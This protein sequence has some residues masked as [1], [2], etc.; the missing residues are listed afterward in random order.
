[1]NKNY[2]NVLSTILDDLNKYKELYDREY[3]IE[4]QDKK[5]EIEDNIN[6]ILEEGRNLK[7]G[8]VGAVKAGKSS[9][10]NALIFNGEDVL[11]KAST[12][13]TAAL[14]KINYSSEAKFKVNF[15]ESKEWEVIKER[16][17]EYDKKFEEYCKQFN[18]LQ[19]KKDLEKSFIHY[20]KLEGQISILSCKELT[21]MASKSKLDLND[22]LGKSDIV[23]NKKDLENYI[24]ANGKYTAIVK[25]V[26]LYIDNS[27]LKGIEIIDTPGLNDPILSRA[28][29][30]KK[31]LGQCDVV[32]VL[33]YA[34]QFFDKEDRKL[35]VD[36]LPDKGVKEIIIV[37]SKF[38]SGV[39]DDNVSE[40]YK[41]ASKLLEKQF[42]IRASEM[43]DEI[44]D[45]SIVSEL[46]KSLPPVC[47]SSMLFTCAKKKECGNR[48]SDEELK[49]INNLKER[50]VD[51]SDD[52]KDL[53][54]FSGIHKI[55]KKLNEIMDESDKIIEEKNKNYLINNKINFNK[56]LEN[57]CEHVK[58]NNKRLEVE[59]KESLEE[60]LS[61]IENK[62]DTI[63]NEVKI[64][65][66]KNIVESEKIL[67]HIEII[68]NREISNY[69][70]LKFEEY[71]ESNLETRREGFLGWR[72][73]TYTVQKTIFKSSVSDVIGTINDYI[74]RCKE[75]VNNEFEKVI[76]ISKFEKELKDI[77]INL[78]DLSD[79]TF[80]EIEI[81]GP[82]SIVVK[83]IQIPKINI[84]E[85][86]YRKYILD[87]FQ[88]PYATGE[89][90]HNL[91]LLQQEVLISI[92]SD[93]ANNIQ[94]CRNN[95]ENVLML[96]SDGL[97]DDVKVRI[98]NNIEQLKKH[99][100]NK[101][102]M[103]KQY[104][105]F[106][107]ELEKYITMISGMVIK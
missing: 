59:S 76:D 54:K 55:H 42:E 27:F 88:K 28:E 89:E 43:I 30:T 90:I 80:N 10:L 7:I 11:P 101:E 29:E 23:Y 40:S 47:I 22:Y 38:D 100:D 25:Y 9:F 8:I 35:I 64:I 56:I 52:I 15:Y 105:E 37:C 99:I 41:K 93:I 24:G 14:T 106:E 91:K 102:N 61:N 97:I 20:M 50:F 44:A 63:K 104:A 94:E 19:N 33:S 74:I 31:F 39:L 82:L 5:I 2:K 71:V 66:E 77:I 96:E 48:L 6:K 60:K 70:N 75:I 95:L 83:K 53:T 21:I 46:K 86:K 72:K 69:N 84:D 98:S 4:F 17:N 13:M 107:K 18:R 62:L 81:L 58:N 79:E 32:F 34:G 85:S 51:F 36:T 45:E 65:F 12:P 87:K 78:F 103:I 92:Y 73:K 68:I 49:I 67:N 26:E 3:F 16:S 57:I 1:M